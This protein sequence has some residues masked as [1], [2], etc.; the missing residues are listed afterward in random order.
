MRN[1]KD[2]ISGQRTS[3]R[4]RVTKLPKKKIKEEECPE[5]RC[6]EQKR[7]AVRRD[8]IEPQ[9]GLETGRSRYVATCETEARPGEALM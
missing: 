2:T 3:R 1:A 8:T 6:D 7:L 4:A 5:A 9:A